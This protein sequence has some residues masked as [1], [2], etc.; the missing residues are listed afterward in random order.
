MASLHNHKRPVCGNTLICFLY[1]APTA[2]RSLSFAF[3][4][5]TYVTLEW[6]PPDP[7]NG[8]I[9][10]YEIMYFPTPFPEDEQTELLP[11]NSTTISVGGL[12]P[13]TMYTVSVAAI[14]VEKG[15]TVE[16]NITAGK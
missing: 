15:P 4:N 7:P 9:R 11:G 10:Q 12:S 13:L 8:I 1:T 6:L 2:P 16:V 3:V 5:T 14:T